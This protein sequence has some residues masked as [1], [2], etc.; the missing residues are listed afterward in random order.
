MRGVSRVSWLLVCHHLFFY[1]VLIIPFCADSV[2]GIKGACQRL[3]QTPA[4]PSSPPDAAL[5]A[6][7]IILDWNVAFEFLLYVALVLS[8][9]RAP[10]RVVR[11]CIVVALA[12][13]TLSRVVQTTMLVQLFAAGYARKQATGM[14]RAVYWLDFLLALALSGIQLY[15]YFIYGQLYVRCGE[16]QPQEASCRLPEQAAAVK[17]SE[18]V[19]AGSVELVITASSMDVSDYLVE[20]T[21]GEVGLTCSL[22]V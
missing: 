21:A 9:L 11:T 10:A 20:R 22:E 14:Q 13:Y 16:R 17:P 3:H 8:R 15:T 1:A 6:V 19:D 7:A 12:L 18:Q 2:F 5:R 4:R